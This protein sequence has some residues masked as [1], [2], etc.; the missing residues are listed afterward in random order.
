[1]K[2]D[3]KVDFGEY[4][5]D[6]I[7]D[8]YDLAERAAL[9]LK[10]V[11]ACIDPDMHYWMWFTVNYGLKMP[12]MRHNFSDVDC[13]PKLLEAMAM[14]FHMTGVTK[15]REIFHEYMKGVFDYVGEDDRLFWGARL[16][17]DRPWAAVYGFDPID[18]T[19]KEA[20]ED[21]ARIAMTSKLEQTCLTL[22][23]T[24]GDPYWLRMAEEIQQAISKLTIRKDDYAYI[25]VHGGG[26]TLPCGLKKGQKNWVSTEEASSAAEEHEGTNMD[27]LGFQLRSSVMMYQATGS[28]LSK[29]L[30][31]RWAHYLM[32]PKF[33]GGA[34]VAGSGLNWSLHEKEPVCVAGEEQGHWYL[35][36]HCTLRG[37]RAILDYG[38]AMND[39]TA[40]EFARRGFEYSWSMG[41][42]K[43]GWV[44]EFPGNSDFME[45]CSVGDLVA[46]S[47]RLTDAG[48][49]DYWDQTDSLVRNMLAESQYTRPDVMAKISNHST[50][51]LHGSKEYGRVREGKDIID[52]TTGIF[53]S[54]VEPEGADMVKHGSG[55]L[56]LC[57]TINCMTALYYAWEAAV[58][59]SGDT[60][61]VNMLFNRAAKGLD[62]YSYL[63]YEG[64][65]EIRN[66]G[67]KEIYVRI[68]GWTDKKSVALKIDGE[69]QNYSMVGLFMVLHNLKGTERIEICFDVPR[70]GASYTVDARTPRERK[71]HIKF[72]GS[73]AV[74]ISPRNESLTFYPF[75]MDENMRTAATVEKKEVIRFVPENELKIW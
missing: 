60:A 43:I 73:N 44:S 25:P 54:A 5:K 26:T 2:L 52:K 33:W 47:I 38:I 70:Y 14:L 24:D 27:S 75:F 1:M 37:L 53:I 20:D 66:K 45:T 72:R 32:K 36:H 28:E 58:R 42:P 18:F 71:Y 69:T 49:G 64:K 74:D 68:P 9:A 22:Y 17:Q 51:E 39:A 61:H 3:R 6:M 67:K 23:Q 55:Q 31:D 7:P 19:N 16:D 57:C 50:A 34:A 12:T 65:V 59:E 35:H 8:T 56:M 21:V 30:A 63:P 11:C 62:V 48:A 29:D 10:G 13:A 46:Y 40:I 15:N 4:Y 41:I